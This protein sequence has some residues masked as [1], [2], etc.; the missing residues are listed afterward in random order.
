MESNQLQEHTPIFI[1]NGLDM[2]SVLLLEENH[3]K[4]LNIELGNIILF[5]F[6]LSFN[7]SSNTVPFIIS[8][9]LGPTLKILNALAKLRINPQYMKDLYLSD[10]VL[11]DTI[12]GK[13]NYSY[14]SI[15][16]P[17]KK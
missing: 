6:L 11:S 14:L 1:K 12:L 4:E 3:I 8:L 9:A 5:D 10:V 2:N 16:Y 13:G 15:P 7:N 17:S